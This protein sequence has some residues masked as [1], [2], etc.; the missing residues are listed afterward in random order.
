MSMKTDNATVADRLETT[1]KELAS[2]ASRIRRGAL[3]TLLLG[4][5]ILG[6]LSAYFY[7]GYTQLSELTEPERIAVTVQTLVDDNLPSMRKTIED[8]VAKQAPTL[9][10]KLSIQV[11]DS[12]PT[13]REK[14]EEY[15]IGQMKS[16]LDQG[17]MLTSEQI[18]GFL[19]NNRDKLRRDARELAKNPELAQSAV[20]D[21]EQALEAHLGTNLKAQA[22]ELMTALN[23]AN[24]KLTKL[25]Q[26]ANLSETE[27]IERRL[28]QIARRLQTEQVPGGEPSGGVVVRTNIVPAT[29]SLNPKRAALDAAERGAEQAKT[30]AKP[31][32]APAS[33]PAKGK[34]AADVLKAAPAPGQK[35]KDVAKSAP[36]DASKSKDAAKNP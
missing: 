3:L 35:P 32:P 28:L 29:T 26:A 22:T 30:D 13:G 5:V 31:A 2:H 15:V 23:S 33:P 19:H 14:L 4:L 6:A 34:T 8:E 12:I 18:A 27:Q 17:A 10:E 16:T 24:S 11:R 7:F 1:R 21:L 36:S 9:A 20:G 25:S